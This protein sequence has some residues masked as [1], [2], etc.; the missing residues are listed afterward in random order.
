M[1]YFHPF[2]KFNTGQVTCIQVSSQTISYKQNVVCLRIIVIVVNQPLAAER[3]DQLSNPAAKTCPLQLR[4]PAQL[5]RGQGIRFRNCLPQA[6]IQ[7][8]HIVK[9]VKNIRN[10]IILAQ[11]TNK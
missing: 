5:S 9:A 3:R 4:G 1:N 8:W 7:R 11:D 6:A 2:Q 10:W